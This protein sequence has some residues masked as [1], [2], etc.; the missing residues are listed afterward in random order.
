[1]PPPDAILTLIERFEFHRQAYLLGK[2]NETQL[3][4]EFVDK[5]FSTLGWDVD[6]IIQKRY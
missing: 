3:R 4:R 1:M 2:Y 5:F 6:M